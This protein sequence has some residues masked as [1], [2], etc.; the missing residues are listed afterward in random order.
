M[1]A[2]RQLVYEL[3][4]LDPTA[5]EVLIEVVERAGEDHLSVWG[6]DPCSLSQRD[7]MVRHVFQNVA[8][9]QQVDG[10]VLEGEIQEILM[11]DIKSMDDVSR[12]RAGFGGDILAA[13]KMRELRL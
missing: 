10:T 1:I 8:V 4:I 3:A 11:L 6:D 12:S 7:L 5:N 2:R 9:D 13:A